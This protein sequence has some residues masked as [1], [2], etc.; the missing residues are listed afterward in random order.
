MGLGLNTLA[1]KFAG[2]VLQPLLP[3]VQ[4]ALLKSCA[5]GVTAAAEPD[6]AFQAPLVDNIDQDDRRFAALCKNCGIIDGGF[7]EW[8]EVDGKSDFSYRQC[9]GF[10]PI[11]DCSLD[12]G[13]QYM[14]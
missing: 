13:S 12:C 4:L 8:T 5:I 7:G 11:P 6:E 9:H 1:F 10:G 14:W 2:N 3:F